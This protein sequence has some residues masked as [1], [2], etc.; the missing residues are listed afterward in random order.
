MSATTDPP[1]LTA[2]CFIYDRREPGDPAGFQ[3]R[4]AD[5]W[6]WAE[7]HAIRVIDEF[8][9]W[10]PAP[11]GARP[12]ELVEAIRACV[13][14]EAALLVRDASVIDAW[15][16]GALGGLPVLSVVDGQVS[17][18]ADGAIVAVP[19]RDAVGRYASPPRWWT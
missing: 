4:C 17:I 7:L 15:A 13:E 1:P 16:L 9:A 18:S 3:Q 11:D 14:H 12:E 5:C 6:E 10:N 19:I 2:S 8:V